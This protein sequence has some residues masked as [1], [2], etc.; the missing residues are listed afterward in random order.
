MFD[1]GPKFNI[2][3]H[4]MG[5]FVMH[6]PRIEREKLDAYV[7]EDPYVVNGLVR[8]PEHIFGWIN[9]SC[10]FGSGYGPACFKRKVGPG[11]IISTNPL[12]FPRDFLVIN[13]V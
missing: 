6:A 10:L 12:V 5:T 1:V 13:Q 8:V 9:R 4:W 2:V 7:K 11:L 3:Q